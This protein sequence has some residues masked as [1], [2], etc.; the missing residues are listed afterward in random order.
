MTRLPTPG[1][2]ADSWG[3]L[4]NAFLRVEH[5]E[6]GTLKLWD[7]NSF[8][9]KLMT[10]QA[11][12]YLRGDK[13]WQPLTKQA[14][15][16]SNVDDTSDAD[17]PVSA[18]VQAALDAK[19][20][21]TG[22][23]VSGPLVMQAILAIAQNQRIRGYV[24]GTEYAELYAG[25]TMGGE[26]GWFMPQMRLTGGRFDFD[27]MDGKAEIRLHGGPQLNFYDVD[28]GRYMLR[29]DS[30]RT[31]KLYGN[32]G[33]KIET[34]QSTLHVAGSVSTAI[35]TKTSSYTLTDADSTVLADASSN[36]VQLTLPNATDC[37][38]R[39][40]TIKRVDSSANNVSVTCPPSQT[41]DGQASLAL[42]A[43]QFVT[44]QSNGTAW[45]VIGRG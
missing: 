38:G 30:D 39:T 28:Y 5:N 41:I 25:N 44:V 37:T 32:V 6:D 29:I 19:L 23:T 14:V 22:G 12:T 31:T 35:T 7:S 36:T 4:L 16:L 26:R 8:T 15:G 2:D 1:H 33:I 11:T 45:F 18:A 10:G 9:P 34:P 43:W 20:S 3:E 27:Q 42:S 40:Y 17:K 13:T 24:S 21:T